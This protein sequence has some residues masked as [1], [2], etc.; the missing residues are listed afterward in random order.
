[1][2]DF[3]YR[4]F[5]LIYKNKNKIRDRGPNRH[6]MLP[7]QARTAK[8]VAAVNGATQQAVKFIVKNTYR[9][10]INNIKFNG[11]M[12]YNEVKQTIKT[13]KQAIKKGDYSVTIH[14]PNNIMECT[15]P[16]RAHILQSHGYGR[17]HIGQRF[18]LMR[19]E[20][21]WI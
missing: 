18:W 13:I 2:S 9:C 7:M 19:G 4:F 1:M 21:C 16:R 17:C 12:E 6:K 8:K 11:R 20:G 3:A 5:Y 10:N 15:A 14:E